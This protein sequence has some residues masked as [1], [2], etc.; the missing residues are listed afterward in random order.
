M[1]NRPEVEVERSVP[2][3]TS[4]FVGKMMLTWGFVFLSSN[5]YVL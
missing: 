2:S 4:M 3:R 1:N 5:V